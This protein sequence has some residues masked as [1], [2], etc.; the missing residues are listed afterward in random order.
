[1]KKQFV[2]YNN[3][4]DFDVEE[5]GTPKEVAEY[6]MCIRVWDDLKAKRDSIK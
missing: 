4:Y 6:N 2:F 3:K 1:M 5:N